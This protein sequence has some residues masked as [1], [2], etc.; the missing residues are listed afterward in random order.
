MPAM[1]DPLGLSNLRYWFDPIRLS[2][3]SIADGSAIDELDQPHMRAPIDFETPGSAPTIESSTGPNGKRYYRAN[4]VSEYFRVNTTT[5][6]DWDDWEDNWGSFMNTGPLTCLG[7]FRKTTSFNAS[8]GWFGNYSSN[9][10]WGIESTTGGTLNFKYGNGSSAVTSAIEVV[11]L[12]TWYAVLLSRNSSGSTFRVGVNKLYSS[13]SAIAPV[14]LSDKAATDATF[15]ILAL[16]SGAD[17]IL[18]G[19]VAAFCMWKNDI[20]NN[21]AAWD[22]VM[23]W[24]ATEFGVSVS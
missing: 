14:S 8:E 15:C 2:N 16:N 18:N 22:K 23:Q 7:V 21:Q 6:M 17:E 9:S 12:N 5:A 1:K 11:S 3:L 19:D 10:G 20:T 24:A 4:A 13:A